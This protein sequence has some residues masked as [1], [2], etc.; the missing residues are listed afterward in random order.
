MIPMEVRYSLNP[1]RRTLIFW[2]FQ[3]LDSIEDHSKQTFFVIGLSEIDLMD[4]IKLYDDIIIGEFKDTYENL[5]LKTLLGYQ[6]SIH[7]CPSGLFF[8]VY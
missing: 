8:N 7:Y 3:T 4:E 1:N 2:N 5:A 6:F